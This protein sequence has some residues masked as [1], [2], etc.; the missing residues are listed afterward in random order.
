MFQ[1]TPAGIHWNQ[2]TDSETDLLVLT[3]FTQKGSARLLS[4]PKLLSNAGCCVAEKVTESSLNQTVKSVL[5][6][7]A[8]LLNNREF[9]PHE[10]GFATKTFIGI[11]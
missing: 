4:S 5:C 1:W 10:L 7:Y 3:Y 2:S 11:Q 6:P 8:N 9:D